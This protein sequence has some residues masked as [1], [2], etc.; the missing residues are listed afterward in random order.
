MSCEEVLWVVVEVEDREE[1]GISY[2][3]QPVISKLPLGIKR[4]VVLWKE[5]WVLE[6]SVPLSYFRRVV[7]E[8]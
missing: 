1:L 3:L 6:Q 5:N 7:V 8:K 4:N 2:L